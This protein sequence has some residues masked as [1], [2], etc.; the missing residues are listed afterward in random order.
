L[1]KQHEKG[2]SNPDGVASNFRVELRQRTPQPA[3]LE[4]SPTFSRPATGNAKAEDGEIVVFESV[5]SPVSL[6]DY[7]DYHA[8]HNSQCFR[9]KCPYNL[10]TLQRSGILFI[11]STGAGVSYVINHLD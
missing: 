4:V 5:S 10:S 2:D 11:I 6:M 8:S 1:N 7:H 3:L 9:K